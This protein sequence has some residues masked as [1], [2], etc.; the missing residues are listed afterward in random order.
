VNQRLIRNSDISPLV[1]YVNVYR[2]LIIVSLHLI[3][4]DRT[5]EA[6]FRGRGVPGMLDAWIWEHH[7]LS[8][9]RQQHAQRLASQLPVT[10]SYWN[11]QPCMSVSY[12]W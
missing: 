9:R 7:D 12:Y 5:L 1:T 6:F 10:C 2:I 8:N 11:A 4:F 3:C